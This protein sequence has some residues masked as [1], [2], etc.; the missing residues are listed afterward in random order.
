MLFPSFLSTLGPK[1][2][3]RH[4][5]LILRGK[6]CTSQGSWVKGARVGI[7][8]RM[9]PASFLAWVKEDV[10][11]PVKGIELSEDRGEMVPNMGI[12]SVPVLSPTARTHNTTHATCT[13]TS[14]WFGASQL[15]MWSDNEAFFWPRTFSTKLESGC[16]AETESAGK[17]CWEVLLSS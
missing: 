3:K 17:E 12:K 8:Q 14:H 2:T 1:L 9:S 15:L 13:R 4:L 6:A 11:Q 7:V 16:S 5:L 10:L